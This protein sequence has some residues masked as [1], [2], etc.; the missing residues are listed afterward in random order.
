[1]ATPN[2][3]VLDSATRD[4]YAHRYKDWSNQWLV[5]QKEGI[6]EPGQLRTSLGADRGLLER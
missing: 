6:S 4:Q 1:M 5:E 3:I 2:Q